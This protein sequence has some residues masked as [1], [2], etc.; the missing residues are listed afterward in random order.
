[1]RVGR[2]VRGWIAGLAASAVLLA[3][4]RVAGAAA[5]PPVPAAATAGTK[6]TPATV[7]AP[8][9][10]VSASGA[11]EILVSIGSTLGVNGVPGSGGASAVAGMVWPFERRF[12]FGGTL[13]ADDLGTGLEE[14]H[15]PNTGVSLGTVGSTHRWAYGGEWRGEMRLVESR[16]LRLVWVAGFGYAQQVLES[17][18]T[19]TDAVS[20]VTASTGLTF[21]YK[22]SHGHAF[23][24]TLGT[25]HQFVHLESDPNRSTTWTSVTFDWRWQGTPKE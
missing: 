3:G 5:A 9:P 20:G 19:A 13:F 22:V 4:A 23:G 1:M 10:A 21:L 18:G 16:S 7:A 12:T 17:F 24:T 25:R 6:A 8:A 11:P 15:D 14:L 2:R